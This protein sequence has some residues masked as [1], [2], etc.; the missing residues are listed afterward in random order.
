MRNVTY[1][2]FARPPFPAMC[3]YATVSCDPTRTL[4]SFS[5]RISYY[6]YEE[7]FE[8]IFLIQR[9][10]NFADTRILVTLHDGRRFEWDRE[11]ALQ[12]FSRLKPDPLRLLD[13]LPPIV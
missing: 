2:L 3:V 5:C 13:M 4:P 6:F 1:I 8:R 9:D 7:L 12:C 11:R 10:R